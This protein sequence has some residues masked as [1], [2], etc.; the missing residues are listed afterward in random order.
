ML[1]A[2]KRHRESCRFD[3]YDRAHTKCTCSYHAIGVLNSTFLR[4]SLKTANYETAIRTIRKWESLGAARENQSITIE[5]GV[6]AFMRDIGARNW[7]G[8]TKRKFRT[9]LQDRLVEYCRQHGYRLLR[10][11]DLNAVTE[12]RATW[13]DAPLTALKNIERLGLPPLDFTTRQAGSRMSLRQTL[14]WLGQGQ[15]D[16]D[17]SGSSAPASL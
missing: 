4:R 13:R 5:V 6:G 2:E 7:Q 15:R 9:L 14:S 11:L 3:Q 10:E 1:K 16:T 12:F 8:S 17:R